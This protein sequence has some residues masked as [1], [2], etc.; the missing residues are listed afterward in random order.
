MILEKEKDELS[1][2]PSQSIRAKYHLS[3]KQVA[4]S[5]ESLVS[6]KSNKYSVPKKFI[7]KRV[8]LII[9]NEL[10]HI[11]YNSKIIAV[12]HITNNLLNILEHHELTYATTKKV[13]GKEANIIIKEMR[14]INYD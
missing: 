4:V 12:H 1:P 3:G 10:L 13:V 9:R 14:N 2:P 11:Y 7:G 5:N 8:D 6:Y